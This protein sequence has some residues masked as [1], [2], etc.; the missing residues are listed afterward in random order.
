[1]TAS[2]S[3][4]SAAARVLAAGEQGQRLELVDDKI[5]GHVLESL[6]GQV[7]RGGVVA[8]LERIPGPVKHLVGPFRRGRGVG[9]GF[10]AIGAGVRRLVSP[11]HRGR[12]LLG[13]RL[14]V[15]GRDR[16][17]VVA[18]GGRRVAVWVGVRA[19]GAGAGVVAVSGAGV[20]SGAGAVTVS[21]RR[22][23]AEAPG[24]GLGLPP[25]V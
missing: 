24:C 5:A 15:S 14:G 4:S 19:T 1:M 8:R 10:R 13:V 25:A 18:A 20:V 11:F 23:G 12:V 7:E 16:A 17:R 21:Q 22:P 9:G 6:V 2:T 3:W